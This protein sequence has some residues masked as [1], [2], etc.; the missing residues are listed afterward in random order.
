MRLA[1]VAVRMAVTTRFS[2]CPH[3][4]VLGDIG[5][6]AFV[7]LPLMELEGRRGRGEVFNWS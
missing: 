1:L 2:L 4:W 7:H 3:V 6:V 5:H